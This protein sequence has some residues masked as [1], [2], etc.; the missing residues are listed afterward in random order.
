MS[1]GRWDPGP[2]PS[3][4]RGSTGELLAHVLPGPANPS[5]GAQSSLQAVTEQFPY[6]CAASVQTVCFEAVINCSIP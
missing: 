1:P 5:A 2:T 4:H 6:T 3:S